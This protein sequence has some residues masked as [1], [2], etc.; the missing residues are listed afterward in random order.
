MAAQIDEAKKSFAIQFVQR[1]TE[2]EQRLHE[3]YTKFM[4]ALTQLDAQ[5]KHQLSDVSMKL[6]LLESALHTAAES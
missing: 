2:L 4:H 6:S 1:Q 3:E 5:L